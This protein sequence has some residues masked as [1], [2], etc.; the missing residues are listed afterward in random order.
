MSVDNRG[1]PYPFTCLPEIT[2][3]LRESK[4]IEWTTKTEGT[5]D[6]NQGSTKLQSS[7]SPRNGSADKSMFG[8]MSNNL[9]LPSVEDD[10][11]KSEM[12]MMSASPL[13]RT[14]SMLTL[15]ICNIGKE[16]M[17]QHQK[18]FLNSRLWIIQIYGYKD[19]EYDLME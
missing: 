11:D 13:G 10:N 7:V 6:P 16:R 18:Y 9:K 12:M 5:E 1:N 3:K 8:F 2:I 17:G 4:S 15:I 14:W 19:P